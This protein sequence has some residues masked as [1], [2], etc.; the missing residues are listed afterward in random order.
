MVMMRNSTFQGKWRR[1]GEVKLSF[2]QALLSNTLTP[3]SGGAYMFWLFGFVEYFRE[4]FDL[5]KIRINAASAGA[6]T[7]V[8]ALN[9]VDFTEFRTVLYHATEQHN[10]FTRRAG[11]MGIAS[12]VLRQCFETVLPPD[13]HERIQNVS[14]MVTVP[15]RSRKEF[16]RISDFCD[17]EE[18]VDALL[19]SSHVPFFNNLRMTR[20]FRGKRYYDGGLFSYEKDYI[21]D[22]SKPYFRVQ[23]REDPYMAER[24]LKESLKIVGAEYAAEMHQKGREWA[25]LA[26][27]QGRLDI[28]PRIPSKAIRCK[29]IVNS[30]LLAGMVEKHKVLSRQRDAETL[31]G[32]YSQVI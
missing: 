24:P 32:T 6:I 16:Q 7:A 17:A 14:F 27:K 15:T 23:R 19:T 21:I 10:G 26:H 22:S 28:F 25:E 18:V 3:S 1:L 11:L 13:C 4:H 29:M 20:R 12:K 8:L 2:Q 9:R 30:S 5:E 31:S